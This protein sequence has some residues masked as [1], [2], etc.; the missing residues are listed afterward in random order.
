[1]TLDDLAGEIDE[2]TDLPIRTMVIFDDHLSGIDKATLEGV[3][4]LQR[5]VVQLGRKRGVCS[6]TTAHKASS[7]AE[8]KHILTGMTHLV[9]WPHHGAS[10]NL[11][12]VL[13]TYAQQPEELMSVIRRDPAWGRVVTLRLSTPACAIGARRALL[14]DRPEHIE[15]VAKGIRERMVKDARDGAESA[16]TIFDGQAPSPAAEIKA[17]RRRNR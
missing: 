6:C 9:V 10:K 4:R 15:A 16:L 7:H 13:A 8:S 11:R 3:L 14:L 17:A 2:E 5:A 1:M 12:R